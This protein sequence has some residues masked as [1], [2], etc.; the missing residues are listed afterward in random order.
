MILKEVRLW[1]GGR[2]WA[3]LWKGGRGGEVELLFLLIMQVN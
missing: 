2:Y 1:L 3:V